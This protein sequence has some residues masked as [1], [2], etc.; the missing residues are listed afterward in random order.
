MAAVGVGRRPRP[1]RVSPRGL[2]GVKGDCRVC[3]VCSLSEG[4]AG[5]VCWG[6]RGHGVS[7]IRRTLVSDLVTLDGQVEMSGNWFM[8]LMGSRSLSTRPWSPLLPQCGGW[9]A[10]PGGGTSERPPRSQKTA[11]AITHRDGRFHHQPQA[12]HPPQLLGTLPHKQ[13]GGPEARATWVSLWGAPGGHP[14]PMGDMEPGAMNMHPQ[15]SGSLVRGSAAWTSR[16]SG[17]HALEA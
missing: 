5:A 9:R 7:G 3:R 11:L 15:P 4:A 17:A 12:S 16:P 1:W 8:A 14:T 6:G 13:A 2:S 10:A